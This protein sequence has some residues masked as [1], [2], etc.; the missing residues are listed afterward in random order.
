MQ[1]VVTKE[2]CFSSTQFLTFIGQTGGSVLLNV[3]PHRCEEKCCPMQM[4]PQAFKNENY[5]G[6]SSCIRI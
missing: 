3:T 4:Q 5:P 2:I 1:P 6:P